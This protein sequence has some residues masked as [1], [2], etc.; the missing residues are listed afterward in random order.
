METHNSPA[1]PA[2][3]I[4]PEMARGRE[5][6]KEANS[7]ATQRGHFGSAAAPTVEA[8]AGIKRFKVAPIR[9]Q[10]IQPLQWRQVYHRLVT[11]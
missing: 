6:P 2:N 5:T 1:H 8:E 11:R 10:P 3:R 9:A 4:A 7:A